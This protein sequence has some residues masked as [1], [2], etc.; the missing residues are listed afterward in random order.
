MSEAQS[1]NR[2]F[3]AQLCVWLR[4]TNQKV[5]KKTRKKKGIKEREKSVIHS[6]ETHE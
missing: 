5:Q 2:I 3:V 4:N 6:V 1:L